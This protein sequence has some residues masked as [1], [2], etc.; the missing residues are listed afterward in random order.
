MLLEQAGE[1]RGVDRENMTLAFENLG[2][3]EKSVRQLRSRTWWRK[4]NA[5]SK[6]ETMRSMSSI[7]PLLSASR[8]SI[9]DVRLGAV[10]ALCE[11]DDTRGLGMM[12]QAMENST[13]WAPERVAE[14]IL[15]IGPAASAAVRE[16]LQKTQT[17]HLDAKLMLIALTGLL[18]DAEASDIL[19]NFLTGPDKE[20]RSAAAR[21]LGEIG[22]PIALDKL[23]EALHDTEWEVRAEAARSLGLLQASDFIEALGEA[24]S[25][26][27]IEVRYRAA[28]ALYQMGE[29]GSEFLK[30]TA[31][32]DGSLAA[33][34]SA[35][36]LAEAALGVE[37]VYV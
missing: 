9:E 33:G 20:A 36:L 16:Q 32:K 34:I 29:K 28:W 18:R 1:L 26:S 17:G 19:L 30:A 8:D 6:L 12:F 35:Q 14:A 3:V 21:A 2:Y 37:S 25:D 4:L 31:S 13:R 7:S 15:T 10:R 24:L 5:V 11:L 23:Q 22:D 27:R